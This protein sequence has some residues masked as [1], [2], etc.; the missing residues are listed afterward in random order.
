MF[1]DMPRKLSHFNVFLDAGLAFFGRCEEVTL[2]KI[3]METQDY[4]SGGMDAPLV[5]DRGLQK[6]EASIVMATYEEGVMERFGMR[7]DGPVSLVVRGALTVK[8]VSTPMSVAMR[9]TITELDFG[10][11]KGGEDTN[12]TFSMV[13]SY[14]RV[15]MNEITKIEIDI[16]NMVRNIGGIDQLAT[17]RAAILKA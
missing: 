6:L 16:P 2:P 7:M 4:R 9:G 3:T 14:Y 8:S 17:T 12:L 1:D 10:T 13:C 5:I 11:W 15:D